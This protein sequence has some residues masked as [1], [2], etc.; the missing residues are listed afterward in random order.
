MH[1]FELSNFDSSSVRLL[2]ARIVN[3]RDW[4]EQERAHSVR[5]FLFLYV[6]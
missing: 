1:Y 2:Y 4:I 6:A 5:P 3:L